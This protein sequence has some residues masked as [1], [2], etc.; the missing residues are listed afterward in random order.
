MTL[1]TPTC[2]K[3]SHHRPIL[4]MVKFNWNTKFE[5]CS[6]FRDISGGE[7]SKVHHMT[8]TIPLSGASFH[9][10]AAMINLHT[11]SSLYL[12]PL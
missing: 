10:Q 12:Q 3:I 5:I 11:K 1:A 4:Y 7:N 8:L 2:G 6:R 9:L